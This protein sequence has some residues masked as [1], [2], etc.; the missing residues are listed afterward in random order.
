MQVRIQKI[1]AD[2]G[3]ASRRAAEKLLADG[4]VTVNG[5]VA[6]I[7]QTADPSEDKIKIDGKPIPEPPK[8]VYLMLHK[9]RGVMTTLH[10]DR[11]RKTV[12]ELIEEVDERVVPVGRL[13]YDSE[14]LLL[15]T[16]DGA[17]VQ[18][19][20][21]PSHE[22]GKVYRVRVKGNIT[23]G[24][25]RLNRPITLDGKRLPIPQI[26]VTEH[27]DDHG[28]IMMTVHTGLNRQIRRM[29]EIAGLRVQRLRRVAVGPISLGE[30]K[31]GTWRYLTS[32][33]T[34]KLVALTKDN[35]N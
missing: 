21:H 19:L 18:A 10:D 27:E 26:D 33:E 13:D 11:G 32:E 25:N 24:V 20:T 31:P 29:C 4:R 30:L 8:H 3:V 6:A 12:K 1:I 17:L 5:I 7:G 9:P 16:N 14:G 2:R 15:M 23:A 34:N 28:T 35:E 22:V